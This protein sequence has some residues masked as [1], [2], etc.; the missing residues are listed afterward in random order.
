MTKKRYKE[1]AAKRETGGFVALPHAVLRSAE[2]AALSPRAV[3]LL[4]DLLAQY[5]GDNNGDLC[6]AMKLMKSRGWQ[7]AATI[8]RAVAELRHTEFIVTT[9]QGG[10]HKASLFAVTFYSIDWCGGKLEINAPSRTHMGTWRRNHGVS[11]GPQVV[12]KKSDCSTGGSIHPMTRSN[13]PPKE[14]PSRIAARHCSARGHLSRDT[15]TTQAERGH[16]EPKQPAPSASGPP[17]AAPASP[18]IQSGP[19]VGELAGQ[20]EELRRRALDAMVGCGRHPYQVKAFLGKMNSLYG[21][22]VLNA[23][24]ADYL[25]KEVSLANKQ[26]D[27]KDWVFWRVRE[28]VGKPVMLNGAPIRIP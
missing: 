25:Q 27:P 12:Q 21:E 8:S 24:V 14:Q 3:K 22:G 28:L 18:R 13:S 23:A 26:V 4:C 17:P 1:H 10:K 11:P 6:A 15:T 2:F 5:K 9:R 19:F 20:G 7:G 16:D